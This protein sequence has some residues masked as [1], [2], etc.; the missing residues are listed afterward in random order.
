METEARNLCGGNEECFFDVA[1]TGRKSVGEATL[2]YFRE[3]QERTNYSKIGRKVENRTK[4][5]IRPAFEFL[6]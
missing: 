3:L 5:Q 6:E 2:E 1:M 4:I